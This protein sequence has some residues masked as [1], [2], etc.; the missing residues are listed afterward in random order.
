M[1]ALDEKLSAIT[2]FELGGGCGTELDLQVFCRLQYSY[3][4]FLLLTTIYCTHLLGL[5]M[6]TYTD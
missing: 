2:V 3:R 1:H 4:M 6:H 5:H